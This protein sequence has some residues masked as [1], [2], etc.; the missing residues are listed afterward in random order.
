MIGYSFFCNKNILKR[1][2][3]FLKQ[4]LVYVYKLLFLGFVLSLSLWGV[5]YFLNWVGVYIKPHF[6]PDSFFLAF[7]LSCFLL[8]IK[9]N[10]I[11]YLIFSV[12]LLIVYIGFFHYLFFG[13]YFTG[14]DISLFFKEFHDT[15]LGFFDDFFNRLEL[16]I[17]IL[18]GFVLMCFVR[19]YANQ[20]LKQSNWFLILVLLSF[21]VIPM[22]NIKRGG[23]FSFPN[24]SQFVYF[25][26]MKSIS[27]YFVDV[28]ISQKKQKSFLPYHVELKNVS[29]EAMTI[30]YIMGEGLS[31]NHLSLYGYDRKTTPYLEKWA[32]SENFYYTKGVSGATVTRNSI[33]GFMNFQK[34][35]ENYTLVQSKRYNLFK[36]GKQASFKTAFMSAQ[37]FSSFPHVGLEYTDYSLYK[38]KKLVSSAKGDDFWLEGLK[39]LSLAV[40]NFVVVQMRAVHSPYKK[41]WGHRFEEFNRFSNHKE[42]KIDDYDNGVLYV[43][44]ILNEIFEWAKKISGKVYVFFASDHN[45]LFG[46]NGIYGHITLHPQVASVPVFLWTND[47][48]ALQNFKSISNPS[49]WE[50]GKQILNLMGYSVDNPNSTDD[51][52][53]VQ[54]SDP[55]GGAGFITLKRHGSELIQEK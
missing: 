35:P 33:S 16:L 34:E 44:S 42:S 37:T 27:S 15:A 29:Q 9:S 23:E 41:T 31:P 8:Q 55:T 53:F 28:L 39:S 48:I 10:R 40:K 51:T 21:S 36:L 54:G 49:H 47:A 14:Y 24:S 2:L 17:A 6:H 46:E 18:L 38:A 30:V 52:I 11:F 25:N 5:D 32:E 1:G 22:Q 45:E 12:L 7:L 3:Q 43:D 50:I 20:K 19:F 4:G 13:R 26:G